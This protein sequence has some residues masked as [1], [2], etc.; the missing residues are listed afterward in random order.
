MQPAQVPSTHPSRSVCDTRP[1]LAVLIFVHCQC[2]PFFLVFFF[3]ESL[4]SH[5]NGAFQAI[6]FKQLAFVG[7][8]PHTARGLNDKAVVA[9]VSGKETSRYDIFTP[10]RT[11]DSPLAYSLNDS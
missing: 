9:Y 6:D 3:R 2:H 1:A 11:L 7:I 10:V 4:T 5:G 8:E